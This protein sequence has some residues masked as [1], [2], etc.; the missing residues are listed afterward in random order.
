MKNLCLCL[1]MMICFL[2]I[3]SMISKSPDNQPETVVISTEMIMPETTEYTPK[4]VNYRKVSEAEVF[5]KAK[6][7]SE[8][9]HHS[10]GGKKDG[11]CISAS[12]H[13]L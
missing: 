4:E 3:S 11:S 12:R 10:R 8:C 2:W 13:L 9:S 1:G 6:R 5:T 7:N